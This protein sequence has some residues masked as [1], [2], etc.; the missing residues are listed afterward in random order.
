M[1]TIKRTLSAKVDK[2]GNSEIML[3]LSVSRKC[4]VR[5]KSGLFIP[6]IRFSGKGEIVKPRGIASR[7][8]AEQLTNIEN[9]L[10]ALER[11]II[12]LCHRENFENLNKNFILHE[13]DRFRRPE[14]YEDENREKDLF[15]AFQEYIDTSKVSQNRKKR[16]P[17]IKS[18]LERFETFQC[19]KDSKFRLAYSSLSE[20]VL[21]AFISFVRE[22]HEIYIT[23]PEI[24]EPAPEPTENNRKLRKPTK[25]GHNRI[26]EILKVFRAF[27]NWSVKKG[28]TETQPFNKISI[29]QERYG[30]PIYLTIE[31]RNQLSE[32][33]F[34]HRPKLAIQRD[35]FIFQC[36]IGC[37]VS[38]L[39][40]LT[41]KSLING[42]VE[43]IP[44][45]TK[46]ERPEVVNVPL[47]A[48]ARELVQRYEPSRNTPLFPFI[49]EQKYNKAIKEMMRIAGIDRIV[50]IIDPKTGEEVKQPIWEVA[51]SHM[52]RRTF[53]GNLYKKVKDP[54]LVGSL[55]GHK[56]GS[57]AFVRYRDIDD[58]MKR[59]LVDLL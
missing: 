11:F 6:S 23:N 33:D 28:Y 40:K 34:S 55:S 39:N 29:P 1:A 46:G 30:R 19:L 3:R 51:S 57:K 4:I 54:N 35:I 59:E 27:I 8:E 21:N 50:T 17:G 38:D 45:K 22:E 36:L 32:F 52:A 58:E 48:Q 20:S 18:I 2:N 44:T 43:Y 49:S 26:V 25:R 56:E 15:E 31:E 5:I 12:N 37:R 10:V 9:E 13:I 41:G 14:A 16:F 24:Y 53:I 7:K 47:N 42:A